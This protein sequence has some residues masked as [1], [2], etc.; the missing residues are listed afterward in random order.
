MDDWLEMYNPYPYANVYIYETVS[1][2][3]EHYTYLYDYPSPFFD[4]GVYWNKDIGIY[5]VFSSPNMQHEGYIVHWVQE[6]GKPHHTTWF[7]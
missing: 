4:W 1:E 5:E 3:Q 2:F 7:D 6:N